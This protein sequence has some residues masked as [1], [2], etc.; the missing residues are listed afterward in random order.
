MVFPHAESC[1]SLA[2]GPYY[3]IGCARKQQQ[4]AACC[5][6]QQGFHRSNIDS[7]LIET[8]PATLQSLPSIHIREPATVNLGPAPECYE[9]LKAP[10]P[11]RKY[12][13]NFRHPAYGPDDS[14]LFT[15]YA[16]D[17]ADGGIH[18]GFAHSACSIFADNR[19]DGYLSTTCDG[20]HGERVQAG[21]DEVLPAAVV[22]YYFYVPYPPGRFYTLPQESY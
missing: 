13:V 10:A 20:E 4:M 6:H 19:T 18:H 1:V 21:W 22:D 15:L 11:R 17:H 16:W 9:F 3:V 8:M 12:R 7:Y 14:P 2:M 5:C